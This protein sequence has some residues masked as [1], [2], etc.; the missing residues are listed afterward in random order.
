MTFMGIAFKWLIGQP[1]VI[2]GALVAVILAAGWFYIDSKNSMI[3][4]Q[5]NEI[6]ELNSQ[7]GALNKELLA[8]KAVID[9]MRAQAAL[10]NSLLESFNQRVEQIRDSAFA[11]IRELES[12]DLGKTAN[13]SPERKQQLENT[14][15][16]RTQQL[17][18]DISA[19]S[20][21]K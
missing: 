9:T 19:I 16:Q 21:G 17:F 15:N 8:R 4:Q 20:R 6:S 5:S 13:E 12:V 10:S 11:A 7:V 3:S 1:Y 2:M 18:D 14:I